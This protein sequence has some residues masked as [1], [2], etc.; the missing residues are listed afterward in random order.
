[1]NHHT[2]RR[3]VTLVI[4]TLMLAVPA[5]ADGPTYDFE[6]VTEYGG[7]TDSLALY[8]QH[9]Y[10]GVEN[11]ILIHD[12]GDPNNPTQTT[13]LVVDS[14]ANGLAV[15]A[16]NKLL[17]VAAA[18][19]GLLIYDLTDPAAP[20]LLSQTDVDFSANL[21]EVAGGIAYVVAN[22][23]PNGCLN[24]YDITTPNG[25]A[26]RG[27]VCWPS[28][29]AYGLGIDGDRAYVSNGRDG[30]VIID[31]SDPDDPQQVGSYTESSYMYDVAADGDTCYI[32]MPFDGLR[33]LDVSD[34][35]NPAP[36]ALVGD[37]AEDLALDGD[38]V[39]VAAFE[40]G[41]LAVD[42]SDP[43]APTTRWS[44]MAGHPVDVVAL[45]GDQLALAGDGQLY[46]AD[47]TDPN[48]VVA[49]GA[50]HWPGGVWAVLAP[51]DGAPSRQPR[52]AAAP[53]YLFAA[54]EDS[55]WTLDLRHPTDPQPMGRLELR[56]AADDLAYLAERDWLITAESAATGVEIIDASDPTALTALGAWTAP[57][58]GFVEGLYPQ[59]RG[60]RAYLYVS[61]STYSLSRPSALYLLDITDPAA[62]DLLST[63][64]LPSEAVGQVAALG[65]MAFV[66]VDRAL[67][68]LD[69]ADPAQP[70][71][72]AI[73]APPG[74]SGAALAS[75]YQVEKV[76][77]DGQRLYV[78]DNDYYGY[79]NRVYA[80]NPATLIQTGVITGLNHVAAMLSSPPWLFVGISG[81]CLMFDNLDSVT[82]R[83]VGRNHTWARSVAHLTIGG[84][85]YVAQAGNKLLL[86]KLAPQGPTL[87]A[88][89]THPT[90]T[91]T[92]TP[93]RTPTMTATPTAS[94]TATASPTETATAMPDAA[95]PIHIPLVMK[96]G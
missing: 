69:Y 76:A 20:A 55:L 27:S 51:P 87:T 85:H 43:A 22:A 37:A 36:L 92:W 15:D 95:Q 53:A 84:D 9:A 47:I 6:P 17:Y 31:V 81:G 16:G 42:V 62:I 59:A 66:A 54:S 77:T 75:G 94:P 89:P 35:A 12:L 70:A 41:L 60:E 49:Q 90:R 96:Q 79:D 57:N 78:S 52:P 11:R 39:Y 45:A 8:G 7:T 93:T 91:P 68:K 26:E 58:R 44:G 14:R 83:E 10:I 38:T 48:A 30:I 50:A 80:L 65:N 3:I 56:G 40:S 4:I 67:V 74:T 32:A 2:F 72:E 21:V 19:Q 71:E 29:S 82:P 1:M 64:T 28:T 18:W 23:Y 13:P 25:P 34:P 73:W 86:T 88:T 5:R 61:T 33:I 63:Y 24:L 46:L